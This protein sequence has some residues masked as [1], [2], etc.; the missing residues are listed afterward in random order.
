[1]AVGWKGHVVTSYGHPGKKKESA[2][3]KALHK[4]KAG[5]GDDLAFSSN[6]R[7]RM[8]I[9]QTTERGVR[10]GARFWR[11]RGETKKRGKRG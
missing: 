2:K 1:M 9:V 5:R 8:V 3:G 10:K 4:Q 6:N 7:S 11:P